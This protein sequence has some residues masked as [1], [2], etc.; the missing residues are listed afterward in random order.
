MGR[1]KFDPKLYD[2]EFQISDRVLQ[3][4]NNGDKNLTNISIDCLRLDPDN[5]II[6]GEI[7]KDSVDALSDDV[8]EDGFK[9]TILAYPIEKKD[10]VQYYQIESGHKRYLAAKQA[11]LNTVPVTVTEPP[12]SDAERRLRL[13]SMNLHNRENPKPS[14][15]ANKAKYLFDSIK[16]LREEDGLATD[17]TTLTLLIAKK[18]EKSVKSIEKY[19]QFLKLSPKLQALADEGASWSAL[20]NC[21]TLSPERQEMIAFKI[22]NEA[23]I[24]GIENISKQWITNLIAKARNEELGEI[25]IMPP[26]VSTRRR[27][28]A[29][30]I[31]KCAKDFEDILNNNV[32]IKNSNK[33]KAIEDLKSI[34]EIIDKKLTELEEE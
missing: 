19:R 16:E 2:E 25:D 20:V 4:I 31:A 8:K 28:G 21:S 34:R 11:G 14:V 32:V 18:M 6:F 5:S 12:K 3:Q 17:S 10:G 1:N 9:G 22:K 29:K 30:I 13:I 7:T 15:Q 26:K 33:E 24:I 23:E 27:D